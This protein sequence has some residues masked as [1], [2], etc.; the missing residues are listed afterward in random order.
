VDAM[1]LNV[2]TSTTVLSAKQDPDDIWEVTVRKPDGCERVF[3]VKHI[4]F[5]VGFMGGEGHIPAIPGEVGTI[6]VFLEI[7]SNLSMFRINLKD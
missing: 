7:S 1:E 3:H 6:T 2:W 5:A 4:V